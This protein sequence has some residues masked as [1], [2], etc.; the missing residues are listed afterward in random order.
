M[1]TFKSILNILIDSQTN[2]RDTTPHLVLTSG[3]QLNNLT[4]KN[5]N[6]INI[7]SGYNSSS[8]TD[9]STSSNKNTINTNINLINL[10]EINSVIDNN[11]NNL[12]S[13]NEL[14]NENKSTLSTSSSLSS[15]NSSL[16]ST[17]N[18]SFINNSKSAKST[19]ILSSSLSSLNSFS[20]IKTFRNS[21][22]S[23]IKFNKVLAKKKLA[24]NKKNNINENNH[25]NVI[26]F[27]RNILV[28]VKANIW[29]TK[30][31]FHGIKYLPKNIGHIN[32]KTSLFHLQPRQMTICLEDL[33]FLSSVDFDKI[34]DVTN[35]QIKSLKRVKTRN[36]KTDKK[37]SNLIN[38]AQINKENQ[39]LKEEKVK[40]SKIESI[41]SINSSIIGALPDNMQSLVS[42][43]NIIR[44]SNSC[45]SISSANSNILNN[46]FDNQQLNINDKMS[47]AQQ[48][49][50]K[51]FI[52]NNNLIS[53]VNLPQLKLVSED[54]IINYNHDEYDI[55]SCCLITSNVSKDDSN[56]SEEITISDNSNT[57]L[58]NN[59]TRRTS[60]LNKFTSDLIRYLTNKRL[61]LTKSNSINNSINNSLL[62]ETLDEDEMS[63]GLIDEE[64]D[65]IYYDLENNTSSN[66][67][68]NYNN[69]NIINEEDEND[70]LISNKLSKKTVKSKF[71]FTKNKYLIGMRKKNKTVTKKKKKIS[72]SNNL[73]RKNKFVLH[74]KPPIWNETNQ[75][76]QL[77][78]GGRV[79]QESA[80]NFQIEFNGKQVMQFGRIDSN[81]YTL[82]FEWPFTPIHAFS[83]ALAN[84]TQRLK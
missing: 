16:E 81:A 28:K 20:N 65:D 5:L 8:T 72:K 15:F 9:S 83:I 33:T 37:Y 47:T 75:V 1:K 27:R 42:K 48:L 30:F 64:D 17:K 31:K 6:I 80:K 13:I 39:P 60:I 12:K 26:R 52:K 29:G 32:Y 57:L 82:D 76:Y 69:G 67:N 79:T 49:I 14:N 61:V 68:N 40:Y 77:D 46:S 4:T 53:I 56:A 38:N 10:N 24:K 23:D 63:D 58:T 3:E 43:S 54:S 36:S 74:N 78:F 66:N 70:N 35:N 7:S 84:I 71:T 41:K 51:T 21:L 62:E 22:S 19:T 50:E 34:N 11:N 44:K 55:N 45:L 2:S 25:K 73:K 59:L 18:N